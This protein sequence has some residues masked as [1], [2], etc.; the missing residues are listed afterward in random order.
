MKNATATKTQKD[1][2]SKARAYF[3]ARNELTTMLEEYGER[4]SDFTNN[5]NNKLRQS[6]TDWV[7][8]NDHELVRKITAQD[9]IIDLEPP[10]ATLHDALKDYSNWHEGLEETR[11][12][13]AENHNRPGY[14]VST[15]RA[16]A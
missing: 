3:K 16:A 8:K 1:A 14:E 2:A 9:L 12:R 13:D 10:L 11:K 4:V 7:E 5:A 15:A 6:L